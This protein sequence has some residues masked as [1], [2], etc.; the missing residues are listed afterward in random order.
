MSGRNQQLRI[1]ALHTP[2]DATI[3]R[4]SVSSRGTEISLP[5]YAPQGVRPRFQSQDFWLSSQCLAHISSSQEGILLYLYEHNA[6]H[7]FTD[8]VSWN[9][10]SVQVDK[11]RQL[12]GRQ[13][14]AFPAHHFFVRIYRPA[15]IA[16]ALLNR[17]PTFC[18][19]PDWV[20]IPWQYHPKTPFDRLLDIVSQIPPLLQ[21][22]DQ[23]FDFRPT[24]AR[25]LMARNL[26]D[27][28]LGVQIALE[29]WH[30]TLHQTVYHSQQPYW[31]SSSQPGLQLP[32]VDAFAFADQLTSLT[33][34]YYWA[35][36]VL[37]YPCIGLLNQMIFSPVVDTYSQG[38]NY[39]EP[40]LNLNIDPELFGPN[41]ARNIAMNIC[42]G[43]EAA[44]ATSTQPDLL[45]F[46]VHVVDT[47]Y[48]GLSVVAQTGEGALELLWLDGFRE[49]MMIKGQ[50]L[51][52]VTM[53][54]SFQD[55]ADW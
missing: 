52:G 30:V 2:L 11:I 36:Q 8:V 44:L 24:M 31:I 16:T 6:S 46:P 39:L 41:K 32:F 49:R 9:D 7:M 14:T 38:R 15:A 5:P 43:L 21:R 17:T 1:V 40:P 4:V 45:A 29:H 28:C 18:G 50:A 42:M 26:L 33:F 48:R 37:F 47:L 12:G 53:G 10:P 3:R 20:T 25:R 19:D 34:L 55:L 27:N 23:L 22:L 35:A 13:F 51:A 54:K